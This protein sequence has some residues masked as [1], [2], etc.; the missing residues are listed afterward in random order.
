MKTRRHAFALMATMMVAAVPCAVAAAQEQV[1]AV[2]HTEVVRGEL[3]VTVHNIGGRTIMA[4]G[5]EG[6]VRF[7]DGTSRRVRVTTDGYESGAR[8]A[9]ETSS[10]RPDGRYTITMHVPSSGTP[11]DVAAV[12]AMPTFMIFDDDSAAGDE[13]EISLLFR[14]RAVAQ[15]GWQLLERILDESRI[16]SL[17]A[18]S[19][20]RT[21]Q[22]EWEAIQDDE[23]RRSLAYM[24]IRRS[25]AYGV[26]RP[27]SA[28]A[29]DFLGRFTTE[30]NARRAAA[31]AHSRRR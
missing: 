22:A 7:A 25:L 11:S 13:E 9:K 31:E 28:D 26:A 10:L 24:E 19:T 30:A 16:G 2:D 21:V 12:T 20:L 1:L 8:G 23:V 15:R 18:A 4:W 14:D 17:D 29:N 27:S 6:R 3:A 5:V